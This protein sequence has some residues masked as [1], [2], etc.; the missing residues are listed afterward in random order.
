MWPGA[1]GHED[2]GLA[3]AV[4]VGD[5]AEDLEPDTLVEGEGVTGPVLGDRQAGQDPGEEVH[6]G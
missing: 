5:D 3:R 2:V 6:V 1:L 4:G